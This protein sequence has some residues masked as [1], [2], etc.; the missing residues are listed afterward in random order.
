LST[1]ST[2]GEVAVVDGTAANVKPK[3]QPW[4]AAWPPAAQQEPAEG[5]VEYGVG[6]GEVAVVDGT[7]ANVKPAKKKDER[8]S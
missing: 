3:A 8:S 5:R 1:A 7:A 2:K 4:K 6:K